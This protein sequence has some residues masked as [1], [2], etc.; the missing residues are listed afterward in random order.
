MEIRLLQADDAEH[1]VALR[2]TALTTD[3]YA[4]AERVDSDP[5]LNV[6]FVRE[7]LRDGGLAAGAVVVA[8]FDPELV[9]VLGLHRLRPQSDGARLWGFYVDRN[10]RRR[11]VGRALLE[12]AVFCAQQMQGVRSVELSVSEAAVT[13]IRVYESAGFSTVE[14]SDGKRRMT[15]FLHSAR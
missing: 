13:A 5:G 15:M 4:F 7:R 14:R 3:G 9:G 11:G 12:H 8:A 1:A 2:R 10:R 6:D